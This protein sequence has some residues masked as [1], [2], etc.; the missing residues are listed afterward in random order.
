MLT[1]WRFWRFSDTIKWLLSWR[2]HGRGSRPGRVFVAPSR[3]AFF[4]LVVGDDFTSIGGKV[5]SSWGE[6]LAPFL[7]AGKTRLSLNSQLLQKHC[8]TVTTDR[9]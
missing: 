7:G 1:H 2:E 9:T 5:R 3:G 6:E 4:Y 8:K